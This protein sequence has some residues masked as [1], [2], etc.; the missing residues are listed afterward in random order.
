MSKGL[1]ENSLAEL[2][3]YAA[4]T[5]YLC[6]LDMKIPWLRPTNHFEHFMA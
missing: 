2:A 6:A 5:S 1:S 3:T 4:Y